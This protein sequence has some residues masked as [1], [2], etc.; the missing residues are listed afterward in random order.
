MDNLSGRVINIDSRLREKGGEVARQALP[1]L[2]RT[3]AAPFAGHLLFSGRLDSLP[4]AAAVPWRSPSPRGGDQG[5]R[6][7]ASLL[8]WST[9]RV[10]QETRQ[11]TR[12]RPMASQRT[13]PAGS[14]PWIAEGPSVHAAVCP[15]AT[16]PPSASTWSLR[17]ALV[18][19][20][21]RLLLCVNKFC[22][23]PDFCSSTPV[24]LGVF[25][26]IFSSK[27]T[28]SW[29]RT[30]PG[31]E[32]QPVSV[33]VYF[34][35]TRV[36]RMPCFSPT[37]KY[38][39]SRV[40]A[41]TGAPAARVAQD[42]P[43]RGAAGPAPRPPVPGCPL[44]SPSGGVHPRGS[45][46]TQAISHVLSPP[47]SSEEAAGRDRTA[48][49]RGPCGGERGPRH[50]GARRGRPGRG[51]GRSGDDG[52][53]GGG[54]GR[55]RGSRAGRSEARGA[56]APWGWRTGRAWSRRS[57]ARWA[58]VSWTR[59]PGALGAG[60]RTQVLGASADA[61]RGGGSERKGRS[62]RSSVRPA[63]REVGVGDASSREEP[64]VCALTRGPCPDAV[65]RERGLFP[66]T[67]SRPGLC[68][69]GETRRPRRMAL[70]PPDT[71][72]VHGPAVP[73]PVTTLCVRAAG[74]PAVVSWGPSRG[75]VLCE[76]CSPGVGVIACACPG[77]PHV[78]APGT[79]GT[80]WGRC[81]S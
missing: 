14:S 28:S 70:G 2:R 44:R 26:S 9:R 58:P 77:A 32:D 3:P 34:F 10:Q 63:S 17:L 1:G 20:F 38:I 33:N 51:R 43:G 80:C 40:D 41:Q 22:V 15:K 42:V 76:L 50:G 52:R 54:L 45:C 12:G 56:R 62:V 65:P 67:P 21:L 69:A 47:R 27:R 16:R 4:R 72:H 78:P 66:G 79:W 53:A 36:T 39:R 24:F 29:E 18:D 71:A 23:L 37:K 25:C 35:R 60:L 13:P 68:L 5:A 46:A 48:E 19:G 7:P 30:V 11:R 61:Q 49:P 8:A 74:R 64:R 57:A 31:R 73:D 59:A 6:T 75:L 55:R 81:R